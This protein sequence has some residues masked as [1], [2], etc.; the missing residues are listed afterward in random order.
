MNTKHQTIMNQNTNTYCEDNQFIADWAQLVNDE[1]SILVPAKNYDVRQDER[2]LIPV[3][4]HHK[5][6]F[7]NREA[8]Y[9]TTPKYDKVWGEVLNSEDTM[10]VG[11]LRDSKNCNWGI[12]DSEGRE[13]FGPEYFLIFVS[14]DKQLFTLHKPNGG[15]FV[16][17]R[18]GEVVVPEGVY[19]YIDGFTKGYARVKIG[20]AT[21]GSL[22]SGNK[23]GIIN[24]KGE[25]VLPIEYDDIW[26]FHDR[27]DLPFTTLVKFGGDNEK[28]WFATG[29]TVQ[30]VPAARRSSFFE[31]SSDYDRHYGDFEGTYAQDVM[32]YDDDTIYDAF[33]GEADAYWNID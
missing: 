29:S 5:I 6:G 19:D 12:V 3:L 17:N 24:T 33:D 30:H 16:C 4:S 22:F 21:N 18:K 23:W 11:V 26:K 25:V 7:V 28:F 27:K 13:L 15:Y 2:L 9:M 20:K 1:A 10:M 31:S 32:G 14:D 8:V